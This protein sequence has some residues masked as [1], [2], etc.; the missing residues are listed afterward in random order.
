M[1]S[2]QFSIQKYFKF[3]LQRFLKIS[4]QPEI[5][6]RTSHFTE[7]STDIVLFQGEQTATSSKHL[8]PKLNPKLTLQ[9]QRSM[10][11]LIWRRIKS[12]IFR[13]LSNNFQSLPHIYIFRNTPRHIWRNGRSKNNRRLAMNNDETVLKPCKR[14]CYLRD[15]TCLLNETPPMLTLSSSIARWSPKNNLSCH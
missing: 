9:I 4:C 5:S 12:K 13:A 7:T 6:T 8:V 3:N 15:P 10:S 1:L 11:N 2:C 14:K